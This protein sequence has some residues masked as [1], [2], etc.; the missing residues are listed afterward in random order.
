MIDIYYSGGGCV[1]KETLCIFSAERCGSG[2]SI[3]DVINKSQM[4]HRNFIM[5]ITFPCET[6]LVQ[7]FHLYK[8]ARESR[9]GLKFK[10]IRPLP[11]DSARPFN[12]FAILYRY[13]MIAPRS[14]LYACTVYQR[15]A[16]FPTIT[17]QLTFTTVILRNSS[18]PTR[19]LLGATRK[20]T[21]CT[22]QTRSKDM[23]ER[24]LGLYTYASRRKSSNITVYLVPTM[25][26]YTQ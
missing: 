21:V 15:G 20:P 13:P 10:E 24:K 17:C 1:S 2:N 4:R 6:E 23:K 22:A 8:R 5:Q 11:M 26:G 16:R 25:L 7:K 3:E 14:S 19:S 12:P 9:S 18:F